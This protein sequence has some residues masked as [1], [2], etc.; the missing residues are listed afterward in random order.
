[1]NRPDPAPAG[2][3]LTAAEADL[4]ARRLIDEA[5]TPTSHRDTT[6]LP[7][8]GPT[9][10]VAQPGRPPMSQRATDASALMLSGSVASL[11]VGGATSLVLYTLGQ[12]DPVTL[13]IG[14]AGPVAL[15]LAAGSL[16][17]SAARARADAH[18]EH[19]HHYTGPVH[20]DQRTT[21][22]TT[23]GVWAKTTN[24]GNS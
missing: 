6:P 4:R 7:V 15:V 17:R 8:Y 2:R 10:P 14:A 3:P 12:V 11:S 20:Q 16:L 9:P 19:H 24:Q 21:H 18:T 1:M 22:T 13:T 23:R 5:Y